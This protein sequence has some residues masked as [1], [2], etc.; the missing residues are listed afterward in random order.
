MATVVINSLR[1]KKL[2]KSPKMNA[3]KATWDKYAKK[4]N[5]VLAYNNKIEAEKKRRQAIKSKS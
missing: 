3:S 4:K 2:P 5:D 1:K